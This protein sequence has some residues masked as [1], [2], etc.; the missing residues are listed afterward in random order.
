MCIL[1]T[2]QNRRIVVTG[3]FCNDNRI[4]L[5][6]IGSGEYSSRPRQWRAHAPAV[7]PSFVYGASLTPI[8][9]H[10]AVRFGGFSAGGYSGETNQVCVLTLDEE[11]GQHDVVTW[12]VQH[13]SGTLPKARAYHTATL[14]QD[15]YLV[16]IGGMTTR[17]SIL[18]EAILD[19]K[20]WTWLETNVSV[21]MTP[22]PSGRHGHSVVLDPTRNRLVLF[23]GGSGSD[24]LRSGMDNTEVWELQMG[25]SIIESLPWTWS[26]VYRDARDD[27]NEHDETAQ[28]S[29][30]SLAECLVLGR[31]H[32]GVK[33]ATNKV[34]LAFG[35]GHPTTNGVLAYD[36][37]NDTFHRPM[38]SGPLP[39]PRF[40]AAAA[41]LDDEGWLIAHGGYTTQVDGTRGDTVVLD[42]APAMK[43]T[44]STLQ[45]LPD[46]DRAVLTY[47][48]IRDED[49][50]TPR[51]TRMNYN[52]GSLLLDLS[53][54]SREERRARATQML[55]DVIASG[56][57]GGRAALILSMVANGSA[58]IGEPDDAN[59]SDSEYDDQDDDSD[60]DDAM[61]SNL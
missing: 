34:L 47:R 25:G 21:P 26:K 18:E 11:D 3:G 12:H 27:T 33:V 9:S 40:T 22:Q 5:L 59:D 56:G 54:I 38:V 19:T 44:F 24:L 49:A 7:M 23:G 52:I 36:L 15:R 53:A 31:C 13:V 28:A 46:T 1:G 32:V 30:L 51:G 58:I 29:G 2:K 48:E 20:T 37:S 14:V 41:V 57:M 43:R 39:V 45:T 10:R 4:H 8:D 35:S 6:P 50:R 16:V 42:L 17:T 55:S 60:D 61:S